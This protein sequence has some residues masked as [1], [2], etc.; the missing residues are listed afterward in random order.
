MHELL[1]SKHEKLRPHQAANLKPPGGRDHDDDRAQPD[2]T[3]RRRNRDDDQQERHGDDDVGEA[4]QRVVQ[5]AAVIAGERPQATA[6]H[7]VTDDRQDPDLDRDA[8]TAEQARQ[9]VAAEVVGAEEVLKALE[10][11]LE[12]MA[13][14]L[15]PVEVASDDGDDD[16]RQNDHTEDDQRPCCHPV[17]KKADERE[18]PE[19][20]LGGAPQLI[21]LDARLLKVALLLDG[22][23]DGDLVWDGS[24]NTGGG[25]AQRHRWDLGHQYR[26]LGSAT[27]YITS[28]IR[29]KSTVRAATSITTPRM[30]G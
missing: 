26:I 3:G 4:H 20:Q 11:R 16:R 18:P 19:P 6:D 14:V 7:Q 29:L 2:A 24:G 25:W 15:D 28:A 8:R 22:G 5:P 27:A 13:V 1:L 30:T 10:G 21:G 9:F 23:F 12:G 17:M